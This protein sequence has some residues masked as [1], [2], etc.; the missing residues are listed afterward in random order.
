MVNN[1]RLGLGIN[2]AIVF[3]LDDGAG[4][5]PRQ[6]EQTVPMEARQSANHILQVSLVDAYSR[7]PETLSPTQRLDAQ[8]RIRN[9]LTNHLL[10]YVTESETIAMELETP[11]FSEF[12][13]EVAEYLN[14]DV[15][16]IV[17]PDGR[18][19]LFSLSDPG[20]SRSHRRLQGMPEIRHSTRD[21]K[22]VIKD[23]ELSGSVSNGLKK[24]KAQNKNAELVEFVG[25]HIHS[26]SPE[27]GCGACIAKLEARGNTPE[28]GMAKGGLDVY[29]KE[30]GTGLEA[31]ANNAELAGGKGTYFDLVHDAYSQGFIIGLQK[32]YPMIDTNIP[33]RTNLLNMARAGKI[34]MTERLDRFFIDAIYNTADLMNFPHSIDVQD[35]TKIAENAMYIGKIAL[36]ITKQ[37]EAQGF[38]FIP[39]VIR[40]G[41]SDTA[42]R[43]L[44]YHAIRNVVYRTLGNISSGNHT[45]EHHG[46]ALIRVG[47]VG[48]NTIRN[49]TFINYIP[50]G[51][52]ADS[53]IMDV[54][55]L[56]GL[57]YKVYKDKNI[58]VLREGRVIVVTGTYDETD[59]GDNTSAANSA[60]E[61]VNSMILGN[62]AAIRESLRSGIDTGEVTVVALQYNQRTRQYT[63]ITLP[64]SYQ[65]DNSEN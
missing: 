58:D 32:E 33:F 43:V 11:T 54:K 61:D 49:T 7:L 16:F 27:H 42:V 40:E 34:L 53:D 13:T 29:F 20:I 51:E 14:A 31:F 15:G 5:T 56:Y 24:R 64:D 52:I 12:T 62:A 9:G 48:P 37:E 35:F 10:P 21:G 47:P 46:E 26:G 57:L 25:P 6:T 44:A 63:P 3:G 59:Y 17:C 23:T 36:E 45:L 55:K 50:R 60:L 22:P 4:N 2:R 8:E 19:L 39:Q 30:I 41:K 38:P 1:E 65:K 18:V 28:V